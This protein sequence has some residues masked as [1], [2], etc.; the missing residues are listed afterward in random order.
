MDSTL[1]HAAKR[2][3]LDRFKR[4][5]VHPVVTR[6]SME[7]DADRKMVSVKWVVTKKG[8][9][10]HPI[11][12]GTSGGTRNFTLETS[13]RELFAGTPGLMIM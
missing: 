3:E 13:G 2:K 9:E 1:V 6:R 4:M 7:K 8:T 11:A 5:K 10:P 12:K